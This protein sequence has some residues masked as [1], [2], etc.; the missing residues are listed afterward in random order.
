M[1]TRRFD[2]ANSGYR[3]DSNPRTAPVS[4]RA[5]NA[6]GRIRGPGLSPHGQAIDRDASGLS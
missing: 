4:M 2:I 1:T 3:F 5:K 6:G